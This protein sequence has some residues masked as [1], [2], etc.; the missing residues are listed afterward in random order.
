MPLNI[1]NK[2]DL[3]GRA[4]NAHTLGKYP[5][6]E[7]LYRQV[8]AMDPNHAGACQ[9]LG[10]LAFQVGRNDAAIPLLKRALAINPDAKPECRLV[11]LIMQRR[12]RWLLSRTDQ[13]FLNPAP[14]G[15]K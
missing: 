9:N 13:L 15:A 8:L 1:L 4:I 11:N 2:E 14:A 7:K 5:E 12:A 3:F 10:V 6:A